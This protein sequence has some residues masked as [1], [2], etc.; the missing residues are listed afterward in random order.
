MKIEV[1]ERCPHYAAQKILSKAWCIECVRAVQEGL[2]DT[3]EKKMRDTLEVITKIN[4][5]QIT[6]L[7]EH[8]NFL[9]RET[10]KLEDIVDKD[11]IESDELRITIAE[12][13]GE[14]EALVDTLYQKEKE[15]AKL[16]S[17]IDSH[18]RRDEEEQIY[19]RVIIK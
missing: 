12:Q 2:A 6:E 11:K 4:D 7:E 8:I 14:N 19:A 16:E 15:I 10:L 1:P 5:E 9:E 13:L 3:F 17:I 18:S